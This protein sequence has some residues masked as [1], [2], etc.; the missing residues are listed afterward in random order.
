[1]IDKLLEAQG[2]RSISQNTLDSPVT[3]QEGCG[4]GWSKY[5]YFCEF[6]VQELN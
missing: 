1:M 5:W 2:E 4:K 6:S 3:G